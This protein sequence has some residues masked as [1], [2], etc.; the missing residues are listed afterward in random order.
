M[1]DV[2]RR[3]D[4]IAPEEEL[5]PGTLAS[6]DEAI[7][8]SLIPIDI[9]VA[10]WSRLLRLDTEDACRGV[11]ISPEVEAVVERGL[12]GVAQLGLLGEL[13]VEEGL[14]RSQWTITEPADEP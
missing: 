13:A 4:G 2:R 12:I 1:E 3:S 5:Q 7:G 10:A 11:C 8:G 6:C 9:E 14:S